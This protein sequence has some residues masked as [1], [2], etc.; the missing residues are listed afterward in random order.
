MF[1]KFLQGECE[2]RFGH[3][4][5]SNE[6]EIVPTD[7]ER[8]NVRLRLLLDSLEKRVDQLMTENI[9][10]RRDKSVLISVVAGDL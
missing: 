6:T 1:M 7:L 5:S 2:S 8:E 4:P 3:C 10:L 9:Q